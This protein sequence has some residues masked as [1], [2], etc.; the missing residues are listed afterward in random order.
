MRNLAVRRG[1]EHGADRV[2][3]GLEARRLGLE[4]LRE[5]LR[6]AELAAKIFDGVVLRRDRLGENERDRFRVLRLAKPKRVE[7]DLQVRRGHARS[8]AYL[9]FGPRVLSIGAG[10][11]PRARWP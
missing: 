5:L 6:H 8:K 1:A 4:D 2:E 7:K 9:R 11:G 3:L 10:L